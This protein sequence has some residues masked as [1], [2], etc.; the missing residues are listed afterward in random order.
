MSN[1]TAMHTC[2]IRQA[3]LGLVFACAAFPAT[4]LETTSDIILCANGNVPQKTFS[5][6]LG[7]SAFDRI[8]VERR[9]VARLYGKR[10]EQDT[11]N[12]MLGVLQ[13][14]DLAGARY[15]VRGQDKAED[16]MYMFLP[17]LNAVRRIRGE[18]GNSKLWGTDFSY[19]DILQ[20]FG[21]FAEGPMT[22]RDDSE[23]NGRKVYV[24][25]VNPPATA[26]SPYSSIL[27]KVDA[28]TCLTSEVEFTERSG[29]LRKRLSMNTEVI[30][31][32]DGRFV[33][34][35]YTMED[36]R[37]KTR[38]TLYL[39]DVIYDEAPPRGVFSPQ[40]FRYID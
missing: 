38:T 9:L 34:H 24:L 16:E 12:L 2:S 29:K 30:S 20:I 33:G 15:L 8:G 21:T 3:L 10:T 18:A 7:I 35:E 40:G 26:I 4:A 1:S 28:L 13:P 23:L 25:E 11:V 14:E 6:M 36:L 32:E 5:Q 17:A 39:G 19:Q 22:R 27:T 31:K 37:E